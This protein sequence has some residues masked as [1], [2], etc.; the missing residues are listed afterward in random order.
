[1]IK[2]ISSITLWIIFCFAGSGS[3][4]ADAADKKLRD[5]FSQIKSM[6]AEFSQSIVSQ[7]KPNVEKSTGVLQ[8]ER[9]GKF[10]WDYSFPYQQQ[11][12]ADG[13]KLWIFDIEMDQVIVK[14][15]DLVLG[16]TPA[17]LLS[18]N[19]D[20]AEKFDVSE[21]SATDDNDKGLF[22]MQLTPKQE[23]TGFEKLLL[24][25]NGNNLRIMELKDAFGQVTRIVFSNLEQNP[26]IDPSVFQFTVPP[27]VDV[28]D[29]TK[30]D[31]E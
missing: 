10:R 24:A 6:K 29:D 15:L 7:S 16:N 8:M 25:F 19:A 13:R 21:I 22:W 12:V 17:V 31:T 27:G 14:P 3:A 30:T 2:T 9:P 11:I 4:Y 1:M 26:E 5:F 20:I 23:E 28:I 18:G